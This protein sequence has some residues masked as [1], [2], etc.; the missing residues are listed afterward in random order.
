LGIGSIKPKFADYFFS[1]A[2]MT[3]K[4]SSAKK[5]QVGCVIVKDNRILS[6]G[7]NGTPAGWDNE[8]EEETKFGNTGY[9]R[10]LTTKP[11]VIHAEA[12]ALMKLV[13]S[14]DSSVGSV[15]FVTHLPCIECAKLVYQ[16]GIKEVYYINDYHASKG[17]GHLFLKEAGIKLYAKTN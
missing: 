17:S 4:L 16:A 8:C 3:A 5:L 13:Q 9:G 2:D 11:E 7:Y 10:K 14:T 15:L 6:I 12:N 1:I